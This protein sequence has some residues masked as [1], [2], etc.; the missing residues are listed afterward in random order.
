MLILLKHIPTN[1]KIIETGNFAVVSSFFQSY[2]FLTL[3]LL[4]SLMTY[5]LPKSTTMQSEDLGVF[6]FILFFSF[7]FFFF[8]PHNKCDKRQV[9]SSALRG[10]KKIELWSLRPSVSILFPWDIAFCKWMMNPSAEKYKTTWIRVTQIFTEILFLKIQTNLT[11][12]NFGING[13][14][15]KLLNK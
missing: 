1:S 9:V 13:I 12:L 4:P 2:N 15:K 5:L 8:P 7:F 6:F 11:F 3:I 14:N 10:G